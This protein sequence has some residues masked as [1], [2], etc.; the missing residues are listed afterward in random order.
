MIKLISTKMTTQN[1]LVTTLPRR[2]VLCTSLIVALAGCG[3]GSGNDLAQKASNAG[4]ASGQI[5]TAA[6]V[7]AGTN[8]VSNQ[9]AAVGAAT[10]SGIPVTAVSAASVAATSVNLALNKPVT[11]SGA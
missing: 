1:G 10:T 11:A 9:P 2:T 8:L 6:T 3:G 7:V 5:D 4:V